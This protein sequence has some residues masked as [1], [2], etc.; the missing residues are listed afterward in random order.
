MTEVKSNDNKWHLD[1]VC[2][3]YIWIFFVFYY[4]FKLQD[5]I[6][7]LFSVSW[8]GNKS[9]NVRM[10]FFVYF[11][12][13][14]LVSAFEQTD[15][16]ENDKIRRHNFQN[17]WEVRMKNFSQEK[18]F[19]MKCGKNLLFFSLD[20]RQDLNATWL[21]CISKLKSKMREIIFNSN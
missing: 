2:E 6:C 16:Q 15:K 5:Y 7:T 12:K 3:N 4:D 11:F 9:K 21:L 8:D 18:S 14:Y 1:Y 17:K 20:K 19:F 10:T 13:F